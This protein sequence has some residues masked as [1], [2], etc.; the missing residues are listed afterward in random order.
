MNKSAANTEDEDELRPEYD[1]SKLEEG[2][3]L[4]SYWM[5]DDIAH[6]FL[7]FG[8]GGSD[9]LSFSIETRKEVGESYSTLAGFFRNYELYYVAAD[10][11]DLVRLRTNVR[12]DPPEQDSRT[13]V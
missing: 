1:L 2:D 11:R 10:E 13:G 12:K 3:I 7:S 9:Y 6:I 5:G 8:F 4:A